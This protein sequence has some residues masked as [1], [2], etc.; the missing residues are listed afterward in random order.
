VDFYDTRFGIGLTA[1]EKADLIA[2]LQS[3]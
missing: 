2:F 3:L 1:P